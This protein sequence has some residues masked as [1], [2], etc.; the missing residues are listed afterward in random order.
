MIV[1]ERTNVLGS[2]KFKELIAAGKI[3]EASEVG[4]AQVRR[5]AHVIDVCLQD[6]DRPEVEDMTQFLEMVVK[7]VKVPIMLDS[8]DHKVL[9]RVAEAHAGQV[10]HQLDQPRGRRGALPEGRAARA[11]LRGGAGR[12]LHRRGQGAGPGRHPRPE[13]RHRRALAPDPDREVRR[14]ARGHHLR[15]ARLPGRDRR[16]ELHRVGRR[17][18]RGH[19]A[20]Q[21]EAAALQDDPRRVQRVVRSPGGR[22]ARC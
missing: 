1:G 11:H 18:D 22:A 12:R 17:D 8:T 19:P 9:R 13:A 21:R 15:R 10:A 14:R 7:K 5:G 20:D 6:P 2:R 4:R 16:P 3:E